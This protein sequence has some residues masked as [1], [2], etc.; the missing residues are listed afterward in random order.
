MNAQVNLENLSQEELARRVF[1]GHWLIHPEY[2]AMMESMER[3]RA[4]SSVSNDLRERLYHRYS[5]ELGPV[6]GLM[7]NL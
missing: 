1:G 5:Q 7:S 3:G 6:P 4:R 2:V